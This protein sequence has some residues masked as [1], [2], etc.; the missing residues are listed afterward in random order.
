MTGTN[1]NHVTAA[2]RALDKRVVSLL[3]RLSLQLWDRRDAAAVDVLTICVVDLP[4]ALFRRA[5]T[6]GEPI[7]EDSRTRLAAAVR[8]VLLLPPQPSRKD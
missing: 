8:A 5:L 3:I 6:V 2:A 1:V 7:P 4:T